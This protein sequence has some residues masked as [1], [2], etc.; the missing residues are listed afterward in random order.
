MKKVA[1]TLKPLILTIVVLVFAFACTRTSAT[2]TKEVVPA[3][4]PAPT[5]TGQ[6]TTFEV[7][8]IETS[9]GNILIWLYNETPKHKANFLKLVKNGFYDGTTF[10]RI[11]KNFMIQGG[12]PNSKD[13]DPNNDGQGGPGY[14]IDAEINAKIT[15][16]YG[17]VAAARLGDEINPQKKSSGSQ[18]FIVNNQKGTHFLDM[19]YTV[20]GTVISGMDVV[21]KI[22][23]QAKNEMDRPLTNIPMKAKILNLSTEDLKTKYNFVIPVF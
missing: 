13:L 18:F 10:H 12:D 9:L 20:F 8:Q 17:S 4:D 1:I 15:H 2:K 19:N 14:T 7:V 5:T 3:P 11:I 6:G 22:S 16:N 23:D 21:E